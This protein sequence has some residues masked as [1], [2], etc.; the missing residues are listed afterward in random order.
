MVS[1][2][3]C[4]AKPYRRA[5]DQLNVLYQQLIERLKKGG[6]DWADT[7]KALVAAQLAWI[8]FREAECAL[9]GSKTDGS[10]NTAITTSCLID[11]TTSRVNDFK[12]YLKCKEGELSCPF[13]SK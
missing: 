8:A 4:L 7:Q 13:P 1:M 6:A 11:L 12:R 3:E 10:F 5:D 9:V 2:N